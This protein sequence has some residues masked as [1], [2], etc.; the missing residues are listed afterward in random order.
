MDKPC[1]N[2]GFNNFELVDGH[3]YCTE[4]HE[5]VENIIEKEIDDYENENIVFGKFC[6][7]NLLLNIQYNITYNHSRY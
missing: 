4:C 1:K 7:I 5:L 6:N 3:Y 2:C